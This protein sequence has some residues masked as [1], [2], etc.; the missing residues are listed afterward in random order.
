MG[1]HQID[2][3]RDMR[4]AAL[5][6]RHP[7][8]SVFHTVG[9]LQALRH[10]YGY[11]PVA[12][13]TSLPTGDLNHGLAFCCVDSWFTGRRLVSLPF[14]DHC[15]PL[16]DSR[17]ELDFLARYVR[18][19]IERQD[20]KYLEIRSKDQDLAGSDGK[21]GFSVASKYFFHSLSLR[22]DLDQL[23]RG[24][25]KDCVQRR[26]GRAQ[27]AGLVEQCGRSEELLKAFYTLF[28]ATRGRHHL[29][30]SPYIWFQNLIKYLGDSMEIRLASKDGA[31]I[32]AILTL[33][34]KDTTYYKYGCS[35]ARFNS[36]GAMPW[37]LWR[38]IVSAKS[39]GVLKFDLGRTEED[40]P[41]LL[42][43]KNHWD[44]RPGHLFYW[45]S[46]GAPPIAATKGWQMRMAKRA[47][48]MMPDIMLRVAGRLL[49]RHIG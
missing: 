5:V 37:L 46:C 24:F 1:I 45:R 49:Y 25:D 6:E 12:F 4:W 33:Q 2:P 9:W 3:T 48:S 30:P 38:A 41:G 27:R 23:L 32:A 40:N 7:R 21:S 36:F 29:P 42:T 8:S 15:E 28:I 13:A 16:C 26:I 34:F 20:L 43:F 18:T 17:E 31:P 14:S 19:V 47:F 10:S 22:P 44:P 35:D 39:K 11:E